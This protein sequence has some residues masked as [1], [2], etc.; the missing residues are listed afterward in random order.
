[1]G[2]LRTLYIQFALLITYTVCYCANNALG[3][4]NVQQS[5]K[6]TSEFINTTSVKSVKLHRLGWELS[7]PV[8]QLNSPDK[9]LLS[10]DDISENARKF[11]YT[12]THCDANWNESNLILQDYMD[13]FE[14]NEIKDYTFS[15]GTILNYTHY[16]LELPNAD[17]AFRISGNYLIRIF[18]SYDPTN[19]VLSKRF[20]IYEPIADIMA[21]IRQPSAGDY[22]YT[23]QHINI[24]ISTGA[25][26][27]SNP[28]NEVKMVV[29]KNYPFQNCQ[30]D[31]KPHIIRNDELEYS[32]TDKYIF[33]GGNEF[34]QFDIRNL[35]YQGQGIKAIDYF[36]GMFHVLLRTD[37][38]RRKLKYSSYSDLNGKFAVAREH[39]QTH[40]LEAD[41][42]WVYFTFTPPKPI[43]EGW[44]IYLFGELT[45][46]QLSPS[47]KLSFNSQ[48]DIYDIALL[49]KQG[50]YNYSFILANSTTGEVDA[51]I[52]EG[53]HLGT[54]NT[55]IVFFYYKPL[56]SKFDRLVGFT[57]VNSRNPI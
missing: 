53:S 31:Q 33:E 18:S 54:E 19:I 30:G 26:R 55:Y 9:L 48:D 5:E 46:W 42:C 4:E 39:S 25:L 2:Q 40:H 6:N 27:I 50:T 44:D 15:I 49:L 41:Y 28:T 37:E 13:G 14:V 52:F 7:D 21:T 11:S 51:E 20:A 36:A 8:M 3:T 10:F 45:N 12:I 32:N 29:C 43:D 38:S 16:R 1:M 57:R 47:N 22:R 24:T 17:V 34:R 56:G 23:G 35:R